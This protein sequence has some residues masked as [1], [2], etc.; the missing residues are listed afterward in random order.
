MRLFT[1]FNILLLLLT[2]FLPYLANGQA[3]E[4]ATDS[5]SQVGTYTTLGAL[6]FAAG[7]SILLALRIRKN[8]HLIA[9]EFLLKEQVREQ[10]ETLEQQSEDLQRTKE[11]LQIVKEQLQAQGE[12]LD[13]LNAELEQ[14]RKESEISK[15]EAEKANQAKS[16]FLATMSHEIRTPMNAVI[17]MASLL[18]ET[19]L[20]AE[21]DE[22]VKVINSSGD[23]LLKVIND[24]LD[25]S[26][27]ES[28][29]MHI[30]SHDFDL[31]KCI[32]EV[33]DIYSKTAAQKGID[34]I[35]ELDHLLPI[36]IIGDSFRIRQIL[37]N[38][39]N[40][41]M[42]FTNR[43]EVYID[44]ELQNASGDDLHI[45]FHVH[46]TGIGIPEDKLSRLFKPFSQ[47]DSSSTRKYGG[48]GLGLAIS[49]RLVKLM[50]GEIGVKST[51]GIGSTFTF[52]IISRPAKSSVKQYASFNTGENEGKRILIV[53]DN[54]HNLSILKSQMEMW[55]LVP[56]LASSGKQALEILKNDSEF[57][58]VISDMQMP[59]I[60]GVSLAKSIKEKTPSIPII[61]LSSIGDE[62]KS[63]Y[64]ELFAAVLTK[65][66]KQAQLF[67]LV[68]LEL[69]QNKV[70]PPEA[71]KKKNI[72]SEDFAVSHPLSILIAED[73][74]VNQKLAI[75]ILEKLGYKAKIAND[76]KEAVEMFERDKYDVVLMDMLMP[77]MDGLEATRLIRSSS[78]DQPRI[79]AM[80][81]NALPEDKE[82]CLLAG[83][84]DYI[85]KP[86]KLE[87]LVNI[88][89]KNAIEVAL[90]KKNKVSNMM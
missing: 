54:E 90:T 27:I 52:T 25:F 36:M 8:K 21:Q 41:A 13:K 9:G 5:A 39:V 15:Q 57:H 84:N 46:D 20:N 33:M 88:L 38:L 71:S 67:N 56:T 72:L 49:E 30:E 4:V 32:E 69:K 7:V 86:I 22:Y 87:E 70:T 78:Y 89:R 77:E 12:H 61:L 37:I 3:S 28:G 68:Q 24:I 66:V 53:D 50:G 1:S 2:L 34:L 44:V 23:A 74:L 63:K 29:N 35:Y 14:R 64:P 42:K 55:K 51:P 43:G 65:P 18:A 10:S 82:Q 62:T 80:T 11:E 60:D 83:M 81:A 16:T 40:N 26:K 76:G 73:N 31:R 6:I 45:A 75:R 59:E 19:D 79:I 47:V 17:G 48:T 85:S 58:L